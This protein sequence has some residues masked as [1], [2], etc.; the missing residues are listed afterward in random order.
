MEIRTPVPALKGQCPRPLDDRATPVGD[1]EDTPFLAAHR[2]EGQ[3]VEGK[4]SAETGYF[5]VRSCLAPDPMPLTPD[6]KRKG[7]PLV[8]YNFPSRMGYEPPFGL[9][10]LP[11]FQLR[12]RV[13][14][15]R[16]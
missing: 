6:S 15:A 8:W 16:T 11:Q 1:A 10:T 14:P 9:R 7:R 13:W 5:R 4:E 12:T 2:G 3:G